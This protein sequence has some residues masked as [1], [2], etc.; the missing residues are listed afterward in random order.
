MLSHLENGYQV[1]QA[2]LSE[3]DRVVV[4][5][6]YSI[7]VSLSEFYF[8]KL[9]LSDKILSQL[10]NYFEFEFM[11]KTVLKIMSLFR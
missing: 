9:G 6:F 3:E 5:L 1:D 10:Q 11:L 2:I 4:S 8:I 7:C